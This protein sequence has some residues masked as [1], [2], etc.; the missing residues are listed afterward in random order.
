MIKL[1]C[2]GTLLC[3]AGDSRLG[4]Q[5]QSLNLLRGAA[6]SRPLVALGNEKPVKA[7]HT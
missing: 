2:K 1:G 5:S 6:P 7:I 3:G 4:V